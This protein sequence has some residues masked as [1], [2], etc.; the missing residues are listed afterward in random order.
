MQY[1]AVVIG[2]YRIAG[3]CFRHMSSKNEEWSARFRALGKSLSTIR[4]VNSIEINL[5]GLRLFNFLDGIKYFR[6]LASGKSTIEL[7]H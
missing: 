4:M 5:K 1:V 3:S 7:N 6:E 2:E